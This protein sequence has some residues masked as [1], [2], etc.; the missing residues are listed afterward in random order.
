MALS[1]FFNGLVVLILGLSA[2]AKLT[3]RIH[4]VN[5]RD[6]DFIV[7]GAGNAGCVVASRLSESRSTRV[8]LIEAGMS[9]E[10]IED[11]IV[12]LFG[13]DMTP[14]KPWNWNYTV[15]PQVALDNRTF[16]YPRGKL[17]GGSSSV[18]FV[19]YNWGGSDDFDRWANHTGDQGWSWDSL[20]PFM[21][22]NE[23]MV[24]PADDHNTTGQFLPSAHGF[25]GTLMTS[26]PGYP[27][28]IDDMIMEATTQVPGFPFNIDM[29]RGDEIGIGWAVSTIGKSKRA[30][31]ATTY[32]RPD[33]IAR[34]NLDVLITAQVTRLIKNGVRGR[35]PVV[36]GVEFSQSP[37]SPKFT[38][39]AKKE[40][41][42]S[43]GSIGSAQ[44]LLLS[45][46]GDAA[47]L[48]QVG[49][50]SIANVPDVGKNLQ[51]HA[52]L[53]NQFYVNSTDTWEIRRNLTI[54]NE[55]LAEYNTTGQGPL[56]NTVCNHMAWLRVP[57]N[58]SIWQ[59]EPDPSAGPTS[60]HYELIF[61][62]GFIGVVQDLPDEGNFFTIT[63]NLVTPASRGSLTLKSSNPWEDPIIDPGFLTS[64]L[65]VRIYR[66]AY[67]AV[68]RFISA[69]VFDGYILGP[70]G[71]GN[72]TTDDEIDAY[73]R[74]Y[75]T[76]VWHPV[77]TA[78]M[79]QVHSKSGV[80][81]PD[82]TVKGVSG[83]R[84]V[85]A[86]IMPYIVAAHTQA[87]VYVIAERA[88][89]LIKKSWKL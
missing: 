57:D 62:N 32:L 51:D 86:S 82:L 63:S 47:E 61:S 79:S 31:S 23:R 44:L 84:V 40:V 4:D 89:D 70:F 83:L 88:S 18:N 15:A 75:T 36:T 81:N 6:Y 17:L 5:D 58:S 9:N 29:N 10:G 56:V 46:I 3:S 34:P 1:R 45:G 68:H 49:I 52:L 48:S 87:A 42:L 54:F 77:G 22:K 7:V 13:P 72:A 19:V 38:L 76:S 67:K 71:E 53:P 8:L 12:P 20:Q 64:P 11:A 14:D 74:K 59:G 78:A 43:A 33:V 35:V 66:E 69:P 39:K 16:P 80:V 26:L 41:I 65:D 50:H 21:R 85:D 27:T 30:S 25:N 28:P 24:P 2:S 73:V 60:G 55:Q 37:S